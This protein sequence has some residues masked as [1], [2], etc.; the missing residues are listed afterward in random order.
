MNVLLLYTNPPQKSFK[1]L[2][3]FFDELI[4]FLHG[5]FFF[6]DEKRRQAYQGLLKI[7]Y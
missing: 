2:K 1:Y 5:G 6:V 7:A 4:I 3:Y